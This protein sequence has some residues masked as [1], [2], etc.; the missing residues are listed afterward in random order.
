MW[1][2]LPN[3]HLVEGTVSPA[4][5]RTSPISIFI[6]FL[7]ISRQA[8]VVCITIYLKKLIIYREKNRLSSTGSNVGLVPW[9]HAEPGSDANDVPLI[10]ENIFW[11]I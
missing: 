7:N 2:V 11:V 3:Q 10:L 1:S 8:D 5:V 6:V 9:G 4:H